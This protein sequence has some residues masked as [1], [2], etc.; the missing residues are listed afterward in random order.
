MA[1]ITIKISNMDN[2]ATTLREVANLIEQGYNY[3]YDPGWKIDFPD[4][5]E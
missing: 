3:G 2:A 1:T 5:E 4:V